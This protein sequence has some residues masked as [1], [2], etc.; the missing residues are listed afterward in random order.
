MECGLLAP[1]GCSVGPCRLL[2]GMWA[3]G[4]ALGDHNGGARSGAAWMGPS[5]GV[6]C[7]RIPWGLVGFVVPLFCQTAIWFSGIL[8]LLVGNKHHFS[9][10]APKPITSVN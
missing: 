2:C 4:S 1:A 8:C 7:V 6:L 5:G 10:P 9:N 3:S